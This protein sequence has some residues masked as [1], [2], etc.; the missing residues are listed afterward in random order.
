M[1]ESYYAFHEIFGLLWYRV[2]L[3]ISDEASAETREAAAPA[4][5][6]PGL[7]SAAASRR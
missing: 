7:R 5:R 4:F 6:R 2:L 1:L 3:M